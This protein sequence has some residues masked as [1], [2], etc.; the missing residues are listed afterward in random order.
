MITFE[1]VDVIDAIGVSMR[2]MGILDTPCH[3]NIATD[4]KDLVT[5]PTEKDEKCLDDYL[6]RIDFQSLMV[7]EGGIAAH[8][9]TTPGERHWEPNGLLSRLRK[10]TTNDVFDVSFDGY[11][12]RVIETKTGDGFVYDIFVNASKY[13]IGEIIGKSKKDKEFRTPGDKSRM[14]LVPERRTPHE[15]KRKNFRKLADFME[16]FSGLYEALG[17]SEGSLSASCS[18]SFR[19][20]ILIPNKLQEVDTHKNCTFY[21]GVERARARL[22]DVDRDIQDLIKDRIKQRKARKKVNRKKPKKGEFEFTKPSEVRNVLD[23]Y[24]IGQDAAKAVVAD[25]VCDHHHMSKS[26]ELADAKANILLVGPTGCGKTYLARVIAKE[27]LGDVPFYETA[28]AGMTQSGYVGGS[29]VEILEGLIGDA[30]SVESAETGVVFLDELDKIKNESWGSGV[31]SEKVQNEL[32]RMLNGDKVD[33]KYGTIDT[34]RILFICGGAFEEL[35]TKKPK[36]KKPGI[37][38]RP[39]ND[40]SE[41]KHLE[42]KINEDTLNKYGLKRE[43]VGRLQYVC[44]MDALSKKDLENILNAPKGSLV[45]TYK[46]IFKEY[47]IGLSFTKGAVSYIAQLAYEKDTGARALKS[48][49]GKTLQGMREENK[50]MKGRNLKI[51]KDIVRK[52]LAS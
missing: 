19:N 21:E 33:T 20:D 28:V 8:V 48:I 41:K 40:S 42:Y 29:V 50:Y 18:V 4:H 13:S 22:G 38:F 49:I 2:G 16:S 31:G 1:I 46:N 10:K 30:G 12:T 7:S 35:R 17:I 27:V 24:I 6:D 43:L 34:S 52:Q 9:R 3:I 37:G 51:T 5:A 14:C 23:E 45:D 44:T 15:N 26:E 11:N 39:D 25:A 36:P 47:N 32:L